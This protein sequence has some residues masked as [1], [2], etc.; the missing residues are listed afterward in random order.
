MAEEEISW[1][2]EL[3]ELILYVNPPENMQHLQR[4]KEINILGD[5][6]EISV[7]NYFLNMTK[8]YIEC[9]MNLKQYRSR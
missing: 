7:L 1:T 6:V 2:L 9:N 8:L 5:T 4:I 3:K